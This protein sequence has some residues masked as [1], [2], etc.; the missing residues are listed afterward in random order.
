MVQRRPIRKK[1]AHPTPGGTGLRCLERKSLSTRGEFQ[2]ARRP[3]FIRHH[4]RQN[5]LTYPGLR[6]FLP[7][8]GCRKCCTRFPCSEPHKSATTTVGSR[9]PAPLPTPHSCVGIVSVA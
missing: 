9:R 6:T 3:R 8:T 4:S 1:Y 5:R 7:H 2:P